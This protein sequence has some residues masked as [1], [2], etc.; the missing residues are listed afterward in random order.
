MKK[1][2]M[3]KTTFIK[4]RKK[5]RKTGP[6]GVLLLLGQS[7]SPRTYLANPFPFRQSS[8]FLYYVGINE[9]D[10]AAVILPDGKEI[11]FG[12]PQHPDDIVWHGP[13]P[14]LTDFGRLAGIR[15][16]NDISEL[17]PFLAT[18]KKKGVPVHYLPSFRGEQTL[19][20]AGLLKCTP[21]KVDKNASQEFARAVVEQRS[22]KGKEEIAEIEQALNVTEKMHLLAMTMARPGA[23]EVEIAGAIQGV[24]LAHG[25]AQPYS[26]IVSI[27]GE[28][29]HNESYAN[30]L[31]KKDL[32]LVDAAAE[33]RNFYASDTTRTIPVSGRFAGRQRSIYQIVLDAQ[34]AAIDAASPKVSNKDLHLIASRK[35]TS[36]LKDMGLMRGDVDEAVAVGAHALFFCHGIGHMLGLDAHDMEDLGQV[37]GYPGDAKRSNQFGLSFLRLVKKLRPGF[38]ITIEPGI[39]FVPALID[40]WKTENKHDAFINYSKVERYRNFGGIRIEDDI[41]ITKTSHCVLGPDIPKEIA[42]IEQAMGA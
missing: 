18:F 4:R 41:L 22:I 9:P 6:E 26:P 27:R 28:V 13:L 23:K 24:A 36:G 7:H 33:S 39:Y 29:L 11:L 37:V 16:T 32:L 15:N 10:L 5:L 19:A 1:V 25:M 12:R 17:G 2:V 30:T 42:D 14:G 8:H 40:R 38:V 21:A 3:N 20:L 31:R 34:L 35:I